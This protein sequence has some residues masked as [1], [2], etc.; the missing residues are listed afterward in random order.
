MHKSIRVGIAIVLA[1]MGG[2]KLLSG[3]DHRMATPWWA[4][5]AAA[6]AE[7]AASGLICFAKT[8]RIGVLLGAGLMALF[9]CVALWRGSVGNCGC[10][11]RYLTLTPAS[12]MR[13]AAVVGLSCLWWLWAESRR[14]A[15]FRRAG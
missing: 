5:Y 12:A 3:W 4:F 7:I 15:Q 11:G 8:C 9:G 2:M 10:L 13:L 1:V 6:L 14:Q